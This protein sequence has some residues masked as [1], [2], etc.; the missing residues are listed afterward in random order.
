MLVQDFS[1]L[2]VNGDSDS[3]THVDWHIAV[4]PG[5]RGNN[6]TVDTQLDHW[7]ESVNIMFHL[8]V[9][10]EDLRA[11]ILLVPWCWPDPLKAIHKMASYH[12]V[13]RQDSLYYAHIEADHHCLI[14][15]PGAVAVMFEFLEVTADPKAME[16]N[17]E[18][19]FLSVFD[20]IDLGT[21]TQL[22]PNAVLR[23]S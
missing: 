10:H 16:D 14:L 17:L 22:K 19:S 6:G 13:G 11:A 5:Q 2:I 20:R 15:F 12:L 21:V 23:K 18:L 7:C 8:L 1:D 9:W 4:Y 3:L